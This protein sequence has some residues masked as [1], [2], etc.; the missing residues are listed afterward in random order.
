VKRAILAVILIHTIWA[1]GQQCPDATALD[2]KNYS[3]RWLEGSIGSRK[4]RMWLATGGNGAMGTFYF[5]DNWKPIMLDGEL[6]NQGQISLSAQYESQSANVFAHMKG[7]LDATGFS[8]KWF[9]QENKA[10]SVRM[11]PMVRPQCESDSGRWRMFDDP[12]WPITFQ[13]PE[14]WH[15][16]SDANG[17]TLTCPDPQ[18]MAYAS[19]NIS[20]R[21][22]LPRSSDDDFGLKPCG[23]NWYRSSC[24]CDNLAAD[25]CEI[26]TSTTERDG[27]TLINDDTPQEWR[28]YCRGGG[29]AG[30]TEGRSRVI[31]IGE[32]YVQFI[33]EGPP[34]G[35]IDEIVPTAKPR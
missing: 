23:K 3:E 14:S 19:L 5:T 6:G 1:S 24:D 13:Y 31:L 17:I 12:R 4:V 30:L 15:L 11:K 21:R 26:H 34:A 28:A 20:V 18:L 35:L 16:E 2:D 33:G 8:G 27:M 32:Q 9:S 22:G 25:S 10:E 29:Y 7:I